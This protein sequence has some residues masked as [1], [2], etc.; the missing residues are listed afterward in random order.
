MARS[1]ARHGYGT[2][3]GM[4]AWLPIGGNYP[5]LATLSYTTI[6]E[7][8][9]IDGPKVAI[10][11]TDVTTLAAS[12]DAKEFLTG[13][14]DGG[15]LTVKL[16]F[17]E[18][19]WHTCILAYGM[20]RYVAFRIELPLRRDQATATSFRFGG[21]ITGHPTPQVQADGAILGE[22]SVKVSGVIDYTFGSLA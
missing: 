21:V 5:T 6:A 14:G 15:E 12:F 19:S 4:V 18:E 13:I 22:L 8:L 7:I 1:K 3:F 2:T 10:N 9:E 17:L 11:F 20:T 16:N